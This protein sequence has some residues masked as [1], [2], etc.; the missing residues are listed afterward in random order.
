MHGYNLQ[1]CPDFDRLHTLRDSKVDSAATNNT[2]KLLSTFSS[3]VIRAFI[4]SLVC[5]NAQNMKTNYFVSPSISDVTILPTLSYSSRSEIPSP[6]G[7]I[8]RGVFAGSR[9]SLSSDI[10][11]QIGSKYGLGRGEG[12]KNETHPRKVLVCPHIP[13]N[14]LE[15]RKK[16]KKK[17]SQRRWY[18]LLSKPEA[19]RADN[20]A[21]KF[22]GCIDHERASYPSYARWLLEGSS[23]YR[24]SLSESVF[25]AEESG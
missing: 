16:K 22:E 9:N 2:S 7:L 8:R 3:S 13:V 24:A 15:K 19:D 11:C 18:M 25:T 12:D 14:H 20:E 10:P 1:H 17:K 5:K 4:T 21:R 23:P 6:P